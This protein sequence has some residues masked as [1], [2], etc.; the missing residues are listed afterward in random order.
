MITPMPPLPGRPLRIAVLGDFEGM[1]TRRWLKVFI[2]RGHEMHAVSYYQPRVELP[3]VTVHALVNRPAPSSMGPVTSPS[4]LYRLRRHAPMDLLRLAYAWRYRR[5]GLADTIRTIA[6]DIFHAHYIVEHAFYGAL[7]GIHPYVSSAWGSDL[8]V[9]SHRKLG[10]FI[11]RFTIGRSDLVTANDPA[12]AQRA[13]DLGGHPDRVRVIRL[14]IDA[15]FLEGIERSVNLDVEDDS[16]PTIISD[17]AIEP[18]YRIDQVVRAFGLVR[19]HLPSAQLVIA[20]D[21]SERRRIER[22]AAE[23]APKGAVRFVG[24]LPPEELREALHSAH[25]YVSVPE[26]DSFSLSTM[27]AMAAGTFPIVTDMASQDGWITHRVNGMRVPY[28]NVDILADAMYE[29]L[30]D[31]IFRRNAIEPNR[32]QVET[33]GLTEKNMLLMERYYYALAGLPVDETRI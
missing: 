25:L 18:N 30:S 12:L 33:E 29:A 15:L 16:P 31:P 9:E 24:A 7:A 8:F 10:R 26:T 22:I 23:V 17:R 4:M 6:P 32:E 3:G 13:R 19:R 20:N 5:A 28:D 14:G 2:E 11:S 21:G 27:E 1:H